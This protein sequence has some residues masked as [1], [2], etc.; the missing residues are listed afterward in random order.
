MKT[1]R[2]A[3]DVHVSASSAFS[4][5]SVSS[6][7]GHFASVKPR[8]TTTVIRSSATRKITVLW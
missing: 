6:G 2:M 3:T 1:H 8:S 5:G 4:V 7:V